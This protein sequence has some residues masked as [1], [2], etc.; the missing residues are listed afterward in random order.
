MNSASHRE[1]LLSP[2]HTKP[3]SNHNHSRIYR[4]CLAGDT[5]THLC[6]RVGTGSHRS[7]S[8][9]LRFEHRCR[10]NGTERRHALAIKLTGNEAAG[11][12]EAEAQVWTSRRQL[13]LVGPGEF[14]RRICGVLWIVPLRLK[15]CGPVAIWAGLGGLRQSA[16]RPAAEIPG[17]SYSAKGP[18]KAILKDE[19]RK[20]ATDR[21]NLAGEPL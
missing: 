13:A 16:R 19:L 9:P 7:A 2:D 20:P 1:C 17:R 4:R 3:G 14:S 5:D 8:L 18:S 11:A 6:S 21:D 15:S 12:F 10:R